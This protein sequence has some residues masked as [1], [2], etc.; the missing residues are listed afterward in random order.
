MRAVSFAQMALGERDTVWDV[1]AGT[2]S[3]AIECA[4]LVRRGRAFA[5]ER[6]ADACMG[7][8]QNREKFGAYHMM[9]A[10]NPVFILSGGGA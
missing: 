3:V 5:I 9:T 4:M 6:D 8:R 10:Q 2:G 1:G 7:M